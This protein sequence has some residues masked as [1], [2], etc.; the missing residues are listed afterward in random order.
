MKLLIAEDEKTLSKLLKKG[1][2][3][4]GYAVDCAF[5]GEEALILYELN[6]Y[7]LMILDLNLP[8]L[9]GEKVLRRIRK[10]DQKFRILILS[11]RG[12]IEDRVAG[13]D[14]G[15][16][17]YLTKPFDFR[18]LEARIRG[19]LRREFI[20]KNTLLCCGQLR[21]DTAL[22]T[23]SWGESPLPLT[24]KE[25]GILEYLLLT[26]R[27]VSAEELLEH[28]WDSSAD[29]FSN[30]LKYHISSLRR[31]LNGVADGSVEIVTL[32]GRGY[33]IAPRRGTE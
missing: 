5:D 17:D 9:G 26:G 18:E 16:N 13:L 24:R 23:A 31:K 22:K 29:L 11:A 3:K 8:K 10:Q 12:G 19:L 30:T 28:V 7:D 4:L 27:T 21:V 1:L 20:Q 33:Y 25:Y 14:Q 2:E 6:D 32:R 15:A